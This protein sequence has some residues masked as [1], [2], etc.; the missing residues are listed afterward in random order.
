MCKFNH[1]FSIIIIKTKKLM[2]SIRFL[3]KKATPEQCS[4]K[5]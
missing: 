4:S 5:V 1:Y 2:N 3:I